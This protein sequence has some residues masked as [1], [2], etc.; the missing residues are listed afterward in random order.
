MY[1]AY[2][3]TWLQTMERRAM[4]ISCDDTPVPPINDLQDALA[5]LSVHL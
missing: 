4:T 3:D 5:L 2:G 1:L